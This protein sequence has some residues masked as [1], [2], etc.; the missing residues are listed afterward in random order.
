LT[1]TTTTTT[2]TMTTTMELRTFRLAT[3]AAFWLIALLA[4]P[5]PGRAQAPRK[6]LCLHGAFGTPTGFKNSAGMEDLEEA[7]PEYE[8]VYARGGYPFFFFGRLWVPFDTTTDPSIA[9]NSLQV[10]DDLWDEQGPFEVI[11]GFSQGAAFTSVYLAHRQQTYGEHG[12]QKA[13][14]VSGYLLEGQSGLI[15]EKMDLETPFD[16]IPSYHWIGWYDDVITP[17]QSFDVL[18]YY[19]DPVVGMDPDGAHDVP[20]VGSERFDEVVSFLKDELV[21]P[22][23]VILA[24]SVS[25][26]DCDVVR[27]DPSLCS[28]SMKGNPIALFCPETCVCGD[29]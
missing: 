13:V 27:G 26:D 24:P 16:D 15:T 1:T 18:P 7:L 6:I 17:F 28:G 8:F 11:L 5:H 4:L 9:D 19:T 2:T 3:A 14:T 23:D 29:P 12:F 10:L 20:Q 22:A 21:C 25:R